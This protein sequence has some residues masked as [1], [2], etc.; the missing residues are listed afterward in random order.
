MQGMVQIVVPLCRAADNSAF[1]SSQI[2]RLIAVVLED[3]MN[4]AVGNTVPDGLG[5]FADYVGLAAVKNRMDGIETQPVEMKLLKP[6]E[7]VLNKKVAHYALTGSIELRGGARR[8]WVACGEKIR[9]DRR[10]IIAL[11]GEMIVGDIGKDRRPGR[12]G[13]PKNFLQ[14]VR[15]TLLPRGGIEKPAV[16]TPTVTA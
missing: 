7:R 12:G 9:S 6:I 14:R 15:G 11:G 4:V 8:C 2:P 5:D 13:G 1:R 16:V 10:Q 3:E